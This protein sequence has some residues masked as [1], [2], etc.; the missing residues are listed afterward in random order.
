[1]PKYERIVGFDDL[2]KKLQTLSDVKEIGTAMKSAV[3]GAMRDTMKV[4]KGLM[5]EGKDPHYTYKGRLVAPGFA[6]RSLRVITK[7]D[8]ARG[9]VYALLGVRQEAFYIIQFVEL[10]TSKMPAEP[11]LR[12]AFSS[13]KDANIRKFGE[14]MKEWIRG[15][16]ARHANA[17]RRYTGGNERADQLLSS[18]GE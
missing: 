10:G 6:R 14:G 9:A 5:P 8:K 7:V 4:A 16:A 18:I 3:G 1:M 13:S 15:I 17:S 11:W 2:A 12:P